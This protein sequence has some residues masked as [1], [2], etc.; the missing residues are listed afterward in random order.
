MPHV[1]TKSFLYKSICKNSQTWF[2][3]YV[4]CPGIGT[5]TL[6][7]ERK[8]GSKVSVGFDVIQVPEEHQNQDTQ[9]PLCSHG[10]A[11]S[12][13]INRVHRHRDPEKEDVRHSAGHRKHCEY[14]QL[15]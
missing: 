15:S 11:G 2:P 14:L 9:E 12:Y 13:P 3:P 10:C 5:F 4:K 6:L 7:G 8:C 1:I